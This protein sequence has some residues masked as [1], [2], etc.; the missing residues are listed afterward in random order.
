MND[1]DIGQ[2]ENIEINVASNQVKFLMDEY[3]AK[4]WLTEVYSHSQT[5]RNYKCK[6]SFKKGG[7]CY[8]LLGCFPTN[9]TPVPYSFDPEVTVSYDLKVERPEILVDSP[10]FISNVGV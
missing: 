8:E 4:K 7:K 5:P 10:R 9:I 6:I 1:F 2:P 3:K